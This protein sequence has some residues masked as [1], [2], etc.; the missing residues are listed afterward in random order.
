MDGEGIVGM[1]WSPNNYGALSNEGH[2][3]RES[4]H[5]FLKA[6]KIDCVYTPICYIKYIIN[7]I[8]NFFLCGIVA[9]IAQK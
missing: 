5:K 4:L 3:L 6:I 7:L 1:F 8:S 9:S 2:F